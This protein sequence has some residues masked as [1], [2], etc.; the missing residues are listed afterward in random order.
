MLLKSMVISHFHGDYFDL[1]LLSLFNEFECLETVLLIPDWPTT[2][3]Q[4]KSWF[5]RIINYMY[6]LIFSGFQPV[7]IVIFVF[8]IDIIFILF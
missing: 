1:H 4:C 3:K 8:T 2:I 6:I 5:N 7:S